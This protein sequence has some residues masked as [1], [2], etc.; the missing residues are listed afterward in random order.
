MEDTATVIDTGAASAQPAETDSTPAEVSQ[1]QASTAGAPDLQ[2]LLK[3][4]KDDPNVQFS[5]KELDVLDKHYDEVD[6]G[7]KAA[8]KVEVEAEPE[9]DDDDAP[10]PKAKTKTQEK[11]KEEAEPEDEPSDEVKSILKDLGAKSLKEVPAKVKELKSLIGGKDAQAVAKLTREKDEM[12]RSQRQEIEFRERQHRE[13]RGPQ[14]LQRKPSDSSSIPTRRRKRLPKLSVLT[15]STLKPQSTQKAP[16]STTPPSSDGM[17]GLLPWRA[18]STR[19][20]R[21]TKTA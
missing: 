15:S 11:V 2:A 9:D 12:V 18:D 7:K 14:L 19:L 13:I 3:R 20:K 5:D 21:N 1:P 16:S 17:T 4:E 6:N 10:E 8:P